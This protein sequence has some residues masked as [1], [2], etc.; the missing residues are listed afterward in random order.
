MPIHGTYRNR[1]LHSSFY[2][3]QNIDLSSATFLKPH[4]C[5]HGKRLISNQ[6]YKKA[7][8]K[9]ILNH[10]SFF[11]L[12][13]KKIF[14]KH[15]IFVFLLLFKVAAFA[16]T[17]STGTRPDSAVVL[18][19][20]STA[21]FTDTTIAV[22]TDTTVMITTA[23]LPVV[24]AEKP[25]KEYPRNVVKFNVGSLL[26]FKNY[27]FVYERSLTRKISASVGYRTMPATQLSLL[28]A[29]KKLYTLADEDE[30]TLEEDWGNIKA[31][32]QTFTAEFRFY[33]GRKPGPRGF[34]LGLYGRYAKFDVDYNYTYETDAKNHLIPIKSTAKGLGGGLFIGVQWLIGKRVALD[35]QILGGHWGRLTGDG[36]GIADL[37][38]L[39]EQDRENIQDDLEE[40]LPYVGDKSSVMADVNNSGVKLKIDGPFMGLRSGIS[41]G[42]AFSL[43]RKTHDY[44]K[45]YI[46]FCLLA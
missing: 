12:S 27:N 33:G 14:M 16:Q 35:W 4:T 41:L 40:T 45:Q 17:D 6:A 20:T 25:K 30:S 34:Y 24:K 15:S 28:P 1:F 46:T 3:I 26:L 10:S 23:P 39:S 8:S 19:D 13:F 36:S 43:S 38:G 21:L 31:S 44:G 22:R 5:L 29:F 37:N 18:Q 9:C 32:N 11:H 7:P 42:I 2:M